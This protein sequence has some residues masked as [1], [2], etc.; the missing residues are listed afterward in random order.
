MAQSCS[1]SDPRR[2]PQTT[3]E[4]KKETYNQMW[5][6]AHRAVKTT[7]QEVHRLS[8]PRTK[9]KARC[10]ARAAAEVVLWDYCSLVPRP[11]PAFRYRK[12]MESWAGPENDL[13]LLMSSLVLSRIHALCTSSAYLAFISWKCK[14][15]NQPN[16]CSFPFHATACCCSSLLHYMHCLLRLAPQ[17]NAFC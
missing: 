5:Q 3:E 13:R 8:K 11:R 17:C 14:S 15:N 9:E 10:A 7:E 16:C 1:R 4:P 6:L 2:T 12:A